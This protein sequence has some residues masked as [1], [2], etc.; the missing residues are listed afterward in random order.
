MRALGRN[1]LRELGQEIQRRE[2]LEIP[3][4]PRRQFLKLKACSPR[5]YRKKWR[6]KEKD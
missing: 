6:G 3:F 4:R 2:N 5:N 1:M